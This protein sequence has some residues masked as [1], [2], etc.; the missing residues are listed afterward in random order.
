MELRGQERYWKVIRWM[1]DLIGAS[2]RLRM[3]PEA[4]RLGVHL[5]LENH[6]GLTTTPE[7]C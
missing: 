1:M 6:W 4:E 5:A 7:D 2:N 3:F